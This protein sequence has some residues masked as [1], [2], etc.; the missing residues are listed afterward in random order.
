MIALK[1]HWQDQKDE[2]MLPAGIPWLL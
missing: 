1:H 2:I